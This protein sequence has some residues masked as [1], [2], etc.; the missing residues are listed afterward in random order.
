[1]FGR[2]AEGIIAQRQLDI[3]MSTVMELISSAEGPEDQKQTIRK[4]VLLAYE[5]PSYIT[6]SIRDEETRRFR[7][8]VEVTCFKKNY[9]K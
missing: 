6:K 2:I 3:S 5:Q 9:N 7:N 8:L 1:M 4:L